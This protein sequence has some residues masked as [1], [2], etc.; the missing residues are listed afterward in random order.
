VPATE[1]KASRHVRATR[2]WLNVPLIT[3][4]TVRTPPYGLLPHCS[5]HKP[6]EGRAPTERVPTTDCA[7]RRPRRLPIG[8]V[9]RSRGSYGKSWAHLL[10]TATRPLIADSRRTTRPQTETAHRWQRKSIAR[11]RGPA[12]TNSALAG[13]DQATVLC[14]VH[15]RV[16]GKRLRAGPMGSADHYKRDTPAGGQGLAWFVLSCGVQYG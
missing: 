5:P 15:R 14:M 2:P 12:P 4:G 9:C 6:A 11:V 1:I 16:R 10:P 3:R 7:H 8:M 13:P